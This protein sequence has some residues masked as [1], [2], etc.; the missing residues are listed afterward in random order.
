MDTSVKNPFKFDN[1][2]ARLKDYLPQNWQKHVVN[3]YGSA[4]KKGGEPTYIALDSEK[5]TSVEVYA[6]SRDYFF[7]ELVEQAHYLLEN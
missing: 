7:V 2:E 1:Q 5:D 4:S 6:G 3:I